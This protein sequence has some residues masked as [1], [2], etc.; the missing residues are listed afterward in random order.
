MAI[1]VVLTCGKHFQLECHYQLVF[2]NFLVCSWKQ[3]FSITK[4]TLHLFLSLSTMFYSQDVFENIV[5]KGGV[6][7]LVDVSSQRYY[8]SPV[9]HSKNTCVFQIHNL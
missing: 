8:Y 6:F 7:L 9:D 2:V 5:A 4:N 1:D 3:Y